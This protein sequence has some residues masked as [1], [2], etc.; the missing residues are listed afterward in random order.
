MARTAM[1]RARTAPELKEKAEHIFEQ[2][3]LTSTDAI[4]IF[5]AQVALHNGMPFAVKIPNKTTVTT[6]QKTARGEELTEYDRID[7]M[8]SALGLTK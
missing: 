1:I 2:L 6:F 3:G 8:L 7:D 5:Y 4:N